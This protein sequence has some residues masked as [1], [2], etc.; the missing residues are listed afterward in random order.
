M[1]FGDLDLH[2]HSAIFLLNVN[3]NGPGMSSTIN[4]RSYNTLGQLLGPW[5]KPALSFHN[6][7]DTF[8]H[9]G[10]TL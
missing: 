2:G 1:S 9:G 3:Q 10:F 7:N 5:C 4:Q 6:I 8:C